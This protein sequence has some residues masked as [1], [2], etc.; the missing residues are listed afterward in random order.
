SSFKALEKEIWHNIFQH[1]NIALDLD[2]EY[3]TYS[4]KDKVLSFHYTLI[5]V[6]KQNQSF[7]K[8]RLTG[9]SRQSFEPWFLKEFKVAYIEMINS[10]L[11]EAITSE[12][13]IERLYI[14]DYYKD[15]LW[16]Q[17]LYVSRV[18]ANDD[19]KDYQITDAAIE[20]SVN[21]LFELMRKGPLDMAIEFA[22]FMYQNK[23]Y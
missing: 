21:L 6:Y 5:E 14:S 2:A 17:F 19:S 1:V 22:K 20:K 16:L 8:H 13:I 10:I 12:E 4:G 11:S 7:V 23:A 9:L 3:L 18:W 15:V